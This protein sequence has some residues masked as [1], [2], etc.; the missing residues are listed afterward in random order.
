MKE[1]SADANLSMLYTNHCVRV[2][3]IVHMKASG[4]E[5]SKIMSVSGHRNIQS[6]EAYDRPTASDKLTLAKAIDKE[7]ADKPKKPVEAEVMP[8]LQS[9]AQRPLGPANPLLNATASTWSNV[10]INVMAPA[11]PAPKHPNRLSLKLKKKPKAAP[12]PIPT[13]QKRVPPFSLKRKKRPKTEEN[14]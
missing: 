1:I 6:L 5:D 3:S 8:P 7:N 14:Q 11:T 10:T 13:A 4:A 9:V 2:T 12:L